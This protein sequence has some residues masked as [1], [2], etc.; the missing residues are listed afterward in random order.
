MQFIRSLLFSIVML[1]LTLLVALVGFTVAPFPVKVRNFFIRFYALLTLAAI[2]YICGIRYEVTGTENIGTQACVVMANHQST[3]ETLA[4]QAI[5]PHLSFVVKRELLWLPFFGWALAML[6]PIAINRR[7]GRNAMQQVVEQG[8]DR[9]DSGIWVV[10]FPE[11]TRTAYGEKARYKKGGAIL[12]HSSGYNVVP[13]A[14]NAGKFWPK[15]GFLKKPGTIKVVIG[16]KII[17]NTLTV[18]EII[19]KTE[20]WIESTKKTLD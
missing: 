14:H 17:S 4:V 5:F 19:E 16:E 18:D 12:A 2:K 13:M 3:W 20:I 10:I 15:K 1:L 11:G 7:S 6:K 8:K 9:L